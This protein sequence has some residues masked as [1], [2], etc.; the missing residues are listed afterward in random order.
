MNDA[1]AID[2]ALLVLRCALGA[3][4]LA[5]GINHVFGGGKIAGTARWF[6]SLGMRPRLVHAW[7]ASLTEI[8]GGA[9]LVLGL[10]TPLGGGRR[11]R[12]DARGVDHQPPRQRLLHLPPRRGLGVR[13]DPDLHRRGARRRSGAGEWSLDD[14]LD[15]DDDLSGTTGLLIA[16]LAGGGGALALLAACYR[17]PPPK[18]SPA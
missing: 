1:D 15:L 18:E 12:R 11:R 6:G 10:F 7:L 3:V 17:P 4:M 14:A 13:D 5:H 8:G 16:A 2:L 9:L